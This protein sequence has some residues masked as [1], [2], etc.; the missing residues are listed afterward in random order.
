MRRFRAFAIVSILAIAGLPAGCGDGNQPAP[1]AA[2]PPQPV[3]VAKPMQKRVS[4]WDEFT[5]RFEA[6]NFVEVRAR[7]SGNLTEVHFTDGQDV[8]PGDL[9]FTID[10]RPFQRTVEQAEAELARSRSTL[11][12]TKADLE[13]AEPLVARG[14]VSVQSFQDRKRAQ[15]EAEAA[16]QAAEARLKGSQLDLEFTE[17]RAP[18]KGRISNRRV[19]VGNYVSGGAGGTLLTTIVSVDPIYFVFDASEADYLRYARLAE[20]GNRPSSRTTANPVQV[21]LMDEDSWDHKGVMNFVDNRL[22]P[23]SGTIR[24]R[25]VFDNKDGFLTPGTF[26]RLRLIGSNEYDALLVPDDR[27][28]SSSW[29]SIRRA[30]SRASR[31]SSDRFTRAFG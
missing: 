7:V 12:F 11:E 28:V 3:T 24:G 15:G 2:P 21:R 5:G 29:R 9:L 18:L 16:V 20:D 30:T 13:R 10:R 4:D 19:D 17:V 31:C 14:T 25:A 23:N 6:S 27:R 8:K 1:Q 22:D 26:G